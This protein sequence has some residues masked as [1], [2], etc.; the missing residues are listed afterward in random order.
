M[1]S[2][3]YEPTQLKKRISFSAL[4]CEYSASARWFLGCVDKMPPCGT[5]SSSGSL[6]EILG[7]KNDKGANSINF[8]N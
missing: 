3:R 6:I 1:N 7:K 5:Y 2:F 4:P 8:L